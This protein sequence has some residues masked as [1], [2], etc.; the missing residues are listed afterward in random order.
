MFFT[1]IQLLIKNRHF[2]ML[3]FNGFTIVTMI[4]SNK[5]LASNFSLSSSKLLSRPSN[6]LLGFGRTFFRWKQ[7]FESHTHFQ[8]RLSFASR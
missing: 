6:A 3:H 1:P 2:V 7:L 5:V 8:G 4:D